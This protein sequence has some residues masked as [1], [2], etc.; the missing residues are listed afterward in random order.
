[1]SRLPLYSRSAL[2]RRDYCGARLFASRQPAWGETNMRLLRDPTL[3][4]FVVWL[5]AP[6]FAIVGASLDRA[7]WDLSATLVGWLITFSLWSGFG[8]RSVVYQWKA[9]PRSPRK[10]WPDLSRTTAIELHLL[11]GT[12]LVTLVS[13]IAALIVC[14]LLIIDIASV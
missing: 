12:G 14:G 10:R 2:H 13:S 5:L 1:M 4:F 8:I 3:H 11:T 9:L 6:I 7:A